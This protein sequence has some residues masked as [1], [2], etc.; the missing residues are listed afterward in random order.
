MRQ[1]LPLI[2]LHG[3]A[4]GQYVAEWPVFVIADDRVAL[5]FT[6]AVGVRGTSGDVE[7]TGAIGEGDLERRYATRTAIVRLHQ[8]SF[9]AR[10]L[11][12]YRERCAV[13]RLRHRELLD[14]AHILPDGH[15][16]GRPIVQNGLSLCTLHHSAFD[17]Y[18]L[19]V[20]PEFR[21]EHPTRCA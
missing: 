2:Y 15:P 16:D 5:T 4:K 7:L 11:A 3:V 21:I 12:A 18:L 19:G 1:R 20:T 10:V 6:V 9:R 14:A 17:R 13:C 8:Q